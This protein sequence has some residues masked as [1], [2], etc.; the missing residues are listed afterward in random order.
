M[1]GLFLAPFAV[2][3]ALQGAAAQSKTSK[4]VAPPRMRFVVAS[5]DSVFGG[6]RTI[7]GPSCLP[8]PLPGG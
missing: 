1:K 5:V 7:N 4:P 3:V 8:A 2:L 6:V